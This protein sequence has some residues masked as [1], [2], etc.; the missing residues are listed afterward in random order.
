MYH[1]KIQKLELAKIL[2]ADDPKH[3]AYKHHQTNAK[4]WNILAGEQGNLERKRNLQS[5][6]KGDEE[7]N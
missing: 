7:D 1:P 4:I 6:R 2:K 3:C 5:K